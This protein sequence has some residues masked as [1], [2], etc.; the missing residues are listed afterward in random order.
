MEGDYM[1]LAKK[2]RR[3]VLNM[4]YSTKSP[5]IGGCFSCMEILI[6]LYFKILN[7]SPETKEDN[8]RDIFLLSKG[9][10]AP[11]LYA[12]LA[13]RGF[14]PK[15][16][17]ES[18]AK[19]GGGLEYHPKRNLDYGIELTTGSL[20]HCISV[21]CGMAKAR[22]LDKSP[23]RV[24]VLSSDGDMQEGA[25]WPALMLASKHKLN[26]LTVIID[27]NKMQAIDKTDDI[28]DLSPLAEK[29]KAFGWEVREING[30]SV[31]EIIKACKSGNKPLA[32][33]CKTIKGKGV[34][35]MENELIWHSKCPNNEEYKKACE[36]LL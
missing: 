29:F 25:V 11:A 3:D 28:I 17:L 13:E 23:S 5:H 34:S 6:A 10:A 2:I 18:F 15:E 31:E 32:V 14:L 35:F 33:I 20:G 16:V 22:K 36:Q 9:H 19:N 21:G 4:L 30:H 1:G 26:N 7:I 8:N 24:F 12:V 27:Y